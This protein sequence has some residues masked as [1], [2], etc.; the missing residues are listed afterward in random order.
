MR[1]LPQRSQSRMPWTNKAKQSGSMLYACKVRSGKVMWLVAGQLCAIHLTLMECYFGVKRVW[2][3]VD[4]LGDLELISRFLDT[5]AKIESLKKSHFV[6]SWL[7]LRGWIWKYQNRRHYNS[8]CRRWHRHFG[9]HIILNSINGSVARSN[10][11]IVAKSRLMTKK[12]PLS[13]KLRSIIYWL[14]QT[15]RQCHAK[16]SKTLEAIELEPTKSDISA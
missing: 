5:I 1:W 13:I 12:L 11:E 6:S 16:L 4:F 3:L 14:H 8:L 7:C 10:P 9:V 2:L 15:W